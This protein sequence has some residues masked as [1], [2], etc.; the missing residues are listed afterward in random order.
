MRASSRFILVFSTVDRSGKSRRTNRN[1]TNNPTNYIMKLN[2]S[3][4]TTM[5]LAAA[6]GTLAL[7]AT[8]AQAAV[9]SIGPG[10]DLAGTTIADTPGVDRL[11]IALTTDVG[12]PFANLAAGTYS[13]RDFQLNVFN[14]NTGDSGA[15][16]IAPMLL[17]GSSGS[18]TTLW[19]G[20]DFDPT[21]DGVQ[22]AAA[23]GAGV[24]TFTLGAA[25]DVYGGM[26]TKLGGGNIVAINLSNGST[27]HDANG[28]TAPTGA[29]QTVDGISNTNLGRAY[30]FEI[31]VEPVPEPSTT[32]LLGLGG[33]ALILRRRK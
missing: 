33:L 6:M 32:A 27:D 2:Q 28:Y 16:T 21:S 22:T 5:S 19:V 23:Y 15:G 18:W 7:T 10:A 13:V 1:T 14:H 11:N 17:T 25:T 4:K 20:D 26:F 12:T 31:N 29:G 8:S 30:A 3:M 24:E 9:T